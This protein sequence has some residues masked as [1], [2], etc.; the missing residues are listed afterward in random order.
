MYPNL[1][2]VRKSTDSGKTAIFES[3][4]VMYWERAPIG[5]WLRRAA[6]ASVTEK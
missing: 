5:C 1:E 4:E 3:G 6:P 2:A